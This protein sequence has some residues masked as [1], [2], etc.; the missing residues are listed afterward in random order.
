MHKGNIPYIPNTYGW[1]D[2]YICESR[3]KDE[4]RI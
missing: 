2:H 4:K 1:Q 3:E